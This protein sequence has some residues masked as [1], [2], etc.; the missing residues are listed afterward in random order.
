MALPPE[1]VKLIES[2][3]KEGEVSKR[4]ISRL[5][6]VSRVT[7]DKI[8]KKLL[9]PEEIKPEIK[10]LHFTSSDNH[11]SEESKPEFERCKGC[12]GLQQKGIPC[13]VC[14]IR[15]RQI[16]EYDCYMEDLLKPVIVSPL[17]E[18]YRAKLKAQ[19]KKNAR[20]RKRKLSRARSNASTK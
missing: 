3:L 20:R 18:N 5:S 8:E 13:M 17:S 12:G 19:E 4:E 1:K 10:I 14:Q 16:K 11:L 15:K 6:K 2:L 7:I 9:F